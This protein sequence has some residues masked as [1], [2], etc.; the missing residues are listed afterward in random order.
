M[1]QAI[2]LNKRATDEV[3]WYNGGNKYGYASHC[4]GN[5]LE[6]PTISMKGAYRMNTIPSCAQNFNPS[7]FPLLRTSPHNTF[8]REEVIIC[9]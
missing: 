1:T 3:L 4:A 8:Q 7:H 6:G 5:T 9:G 2:W